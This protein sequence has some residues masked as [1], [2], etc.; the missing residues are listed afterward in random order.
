MEPTSRGTPSSCARAT[1][2]RTRFAPP[3]SSTVS[4]ITPRPPRAG[5]RHS[6][7]PTGPCWRWAPPSSHPISPRPS[8]SRS[9]P[10]PSWPP[11][12]ASSTRWRRSATLPEPTSRCSLMPSATTNA[13]AGA[14]WEPASDLAEA[15]CP[16][17]FA[18]SWRAPRNWGGENPWPSS[19]KWTPSTCVGEA[20]QSRPP[21]PPWEAASRAPT[22][23]SWAR[24]S[25]PTPTTCVIRPP[26][27]WPRVCT[28][29]EHACASPTRSRCPT[30]LP[31]SPT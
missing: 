22:S 4:P 14:P 17:T 15:V 2:W 28:S 5:A 3:A 1:P 18:H 10:T 7:R 6:T 25:S 13:S 8:W 19:R 21:R 24:P 23:P 27:M 31:T 9:P 26:W 11:R 29:V 20:G 16:R 30:R 12:S